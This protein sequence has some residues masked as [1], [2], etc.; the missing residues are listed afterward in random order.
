MIMAKFK[1]EKA[2][3]KE[4]REQ[5]EKVFELL[6]PYD[7]D[8]SYPAF[9]AAFIQVVTDSSAKFLT[10][11]QAF[12]RSYVVLEHGFDIATTSSI[13]S[14]MDYETQ[15]RIRSSL[16]SV[17]ASSIKAQTAKAQSVEAAALGAKEKA[18]GVAMRH[19]RGPA[20][21]YMGRTTTET[22]GLKGYRRA[23]SGSETCSFCEMLADRGAVYD[24]ETVRFRAHDRCD[25]LGIPEV[26]GPKPTMAQEYVASERSP[27]KAKKADPEKVAEHIKQ[28]EE[29]QKSK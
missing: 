1:A 11:E 9:E 27:G 28:W 13:H 26:D 24:Y 6:D 23:M 25:C 19:S 18:Y 29:R 21:D 5:F 10:I 2:I 14:L 20:R 8:L 15:D 22:K 16:R 17:T 4:M 3:D 12:L 7:L